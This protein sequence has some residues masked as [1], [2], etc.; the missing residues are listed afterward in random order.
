MK[1]HVFHYDKT[2]RKPVFPSCWIKLF[3]PLYLGSVRT[4]TW[5][6]KPKRFQCGE[7]EISEGSIGKVCLRLHPGRVSGAHP[8]DPVNLEAFRRLLS[9]QPALLT[10]AESQG[11]VSDCLG[12]WQRQNRW[13]VRNL[14]GAVTPMS[15]ACTHFCL[16]GVWGRVN[17]P[18]SA[19]SVAWK[20]LSLDH[21]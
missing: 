19:S 16:D 8:W 4:I 6:C 3:P 15:R 2:C 18:F 21:S 12:C 5:W 9:P 13:P 11:A 1:Q 10:P 7:L 20:C 17:L 14:K